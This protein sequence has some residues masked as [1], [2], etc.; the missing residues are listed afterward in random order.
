M[1]SKWTTGELLAG[2]TFQV[3]ATTV[4]VWFVLTKLV[5]WLCMILFH[6]GGLSLLSLGIIGVCSFLASL[7]GLKTYFNK[8]LSSDEEA[9]SVRED[10][11]VSQGASEKDCC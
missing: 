7:K 5:S 9:E 1:N 6:W 8:G 4:V 3:V 2:K 11:S 10:S